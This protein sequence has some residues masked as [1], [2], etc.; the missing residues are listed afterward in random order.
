MGWNFFAARRDQPTTYYGPNS[1][2]GITLRAAEG[3][4]PLKVGVI[5]L[6]VGTLAAYGR[7]GDHYEF[8]EINPLVVQ[9]A[10][11]EFHFSVTQRPR[12]TSS[13]GMR[14]FRWSGNGPRV[15]TCSRW[16]PFPA[17]RSRFI[18]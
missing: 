6:G 8:Y 15:L 16:M 10:H 11:Q 4:T 12:L 9:L 1:G 14:A 17:T 2:I 13:W 3:P 7:P 18:C 5:G